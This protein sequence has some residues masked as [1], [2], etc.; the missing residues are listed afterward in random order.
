M[1]L[2][3]YDITGGQPRGATR[4]RIKIFGKKTREGK[5]VNAE[6]SSNKLQTMQTQNYTKQVIAIQSLQIGSSIR[7]F[8]F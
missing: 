4:A 5:T 3:V 7:H 2:N 6:N 1:L 8:H